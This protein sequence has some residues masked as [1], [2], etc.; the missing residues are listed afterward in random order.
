M[1]SIGGFLLLLACFNYINIA[2]TSAAKRLKEIGVRKSIGAT[3]RTI[4]VQFLSENIV[5]TLFAMV[6][7]ITF[8]MTV[9]IPGFEHLWVSLDMNFKLTDPNLWIYLSAILLFT[10]I[11]SGIY[12]SLYI[13]N[14]QVAGILKGTVKFGQKNPLTDRKSVV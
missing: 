14:F 5:I 6:L 10:S 1:A 13:S 7:G 4:I 3:R 12:P 9:F 2:I 11:A 8:G